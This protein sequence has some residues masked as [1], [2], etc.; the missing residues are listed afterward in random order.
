MPMLGDVLID[1]ARTERVLY[2]NTVTEHAVEDG[3]EIADHLRRQPRTLSLSCTI[4]GAD[5]ETRYQRLK[6]LAD[7]QELLTWV[8]AELWENMVIES[9]EPTRTGQ[10]AN[11]V[12]FELTLRQVRVARVEERTFLAPDPVTQA[13]VETEPVVRG[14]QQPPVEEVDEE[15]GAS[16]L[17]QLGRSVGDLGSGALAMIGGVR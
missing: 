13:P 7:G 3:Q 10:V 17:V 1:V 9:L 12:R 6:E 4:A 15:T 14:L 8:G 5:W 16:W 2:R 11:G